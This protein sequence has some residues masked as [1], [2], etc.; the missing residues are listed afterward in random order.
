MLKNKKNIRKNTMKKSQLKNIIRESIKQ[1]MNEQNPN[2]PLCAGITATP[3]ANTPSPTT[4]SVSHQCV[5]LNGLQ[6]HTGDVFSN[7]N[8]FPGIRF[9]ITSI[10]QPT[11][12]TLQDFNKEPNC[13][14][15]TSQGPCNPGAWSNHSNWVSTF[16]NTVNNHNNPCNFLNKRMAQFLNKLQGTGAGGYQ[17]MQ[18]CKYQYAYQL[19]N[20]NNC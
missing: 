13:G 1:L 2:P 7:P 12:T 5:T 17:N 15:T 6:P 10:S 14:V 19:H 20:A 4:T 8:Q 11:S 9:E 3:C 18:K 16:A